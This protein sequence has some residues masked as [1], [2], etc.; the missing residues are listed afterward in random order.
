MAARSATHPQT[1]STSQTR[2]G[3]S[4]PHA[5]VPSAS[6]ASLAGR[7]SQSRENTSRASINCACHVISQSASTNTLSMICKTIS[8]QVSPS[9]SGTFLTRSSKKWSAPLRNMYAVRILNARVSGTSIA[10]G[11]AQMISLALIV[12]LLGEC[13]VSTSIQSL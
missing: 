8:I 1:T 4:A 2:P 5:S 10:H 9:G 11:A 13:L 3:H 7:P 12:K 6:T